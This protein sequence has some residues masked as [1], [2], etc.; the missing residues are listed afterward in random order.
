MSHTGFRLEVTVHVHMEFVA[1][2]G[3]SISRRLCGCRVAIAIASR[4]ESEHAV[5]LSASDGIMSITHHHVA[6]DATRFA[7]VDVVVNR[8]GSPVG[9]ALTPLTSCL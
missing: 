6:V 1:G 9:T 3:C 8:H 7:V 2:P 5:C 4:A